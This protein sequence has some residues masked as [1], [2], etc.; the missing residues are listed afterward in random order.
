VEGGFD[1]AI[2]N[3]ALKDSSLIA[4]QLAPDRRILCAAPSY[5][6]ANDAPQTP[7]DLLHH[8]CLILPGIDHWLFE[9]E[10]GPITIKPQGNF[11]VDNGEAVRD[12]CIQGLGITINSTWS[13]FEALESGALVQVLERYPLVANTFAQQFG[14]TPYWDATLLTQR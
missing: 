5:L 2:R 4:R 1:I 10:S 6:A 12:A 7:Q 8:N 14:R 3:A 9:S 11:K 13:A